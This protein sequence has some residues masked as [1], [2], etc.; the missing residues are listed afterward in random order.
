MRPFYLKMLV[1]DDDPIISRMIRDYFAASQTYEF[2]HAEDGEQGLAIAIQ[3]L[4]DI[5]LTDLM[6]PKKSGIELIKELRRMEEFAVTPIVAITAGNEAMQDD[7]K[8]AGASMVIV[9]PFRRL[10]FVE[11]IDSLVEANPFIR[12]R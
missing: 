12:K 11:R 2:F 10:D 6:L 8:Q 1:I 7:A 5:V 3:E 9:K 4:P